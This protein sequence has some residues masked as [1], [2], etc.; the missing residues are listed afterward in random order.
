MSV[1]NWARY[2][3]GDEPIEGEVEEATPLRPRAQFFRREPVDVTPEEAQPP[4]R[5]WKKQ[6]TLHFAEAERRKTAARDR[7]IG[8]AIWF[9]LSFVLPGLLKYAAWWI[10]VAMGVA[11]IWNAEQ[12]LLAHRQGSITLDDV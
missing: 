6:Q 12:W 3:G 1:S 2:H 10:C 8:A 5:W 11:A 9:A 4:Y 7:A